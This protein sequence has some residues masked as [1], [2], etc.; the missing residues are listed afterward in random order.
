MSLSLFPPVI[1]SAAARIP[2]VHM[3][4]MQMASSWRSLGHPWRGTVRHERLRSSQRG[5][6]LSAFPCSEQGIQIQLFCGLTIARD[7]QTLK[8]LCVQRIWS[9]VLDI[10]LGYGIKDMTAGE[11]EHIFKCFFLLWIA[12]CYPLPILFGGFIDLWWFFIDFFLIYF[13]LLVGVFIDF[14]HESLGR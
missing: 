1:N 3:G 12:G 8:S 7:P 13:F 4:E 9:A 14:Q 10:C 11:V 5:G 6:S 2:A